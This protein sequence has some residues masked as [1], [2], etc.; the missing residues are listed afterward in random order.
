MREALARSDRDF[1]I[2]DDAE[3]MPSRLIGALQLILS[4]PLEIPGALTMA[5]FAV[6]IVFNALALQTG[7]HP[8]PFF[9]RPDQRQAQAATTRSLT[10]APVSGDVTASLSE[11]AALVRDL[12]LEL[13][14]VGLYDGTA[15]GLFGPRT[16]AAIR[17]YQEKVGL[18]QDGRASPDLLIRMR[19]TPLP[20]A[21]PAAP[22]TQPANGDAIA[23]LIESDMPSRAVQPDK[24]VLRV[25]RALS[26][27][28]YGPLKVDGI[29]DE[30]TRTAIGQFEMD[31]SM[32]VTG[33]ISAR[34]EKELTNMLGA[35]LE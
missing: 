5:G 26:K 19:S 14:E 28:A 16:A 20:P 31:R 23:A 25:E 3:E 22:V 10:P 8:Q 27:L 15:D 7:M 6:A 17:V 2:S 24:R 9:A 35:P 32:P 4:H 21:R 13:S 30:E 1:L 11:Q 12:Q 29:A 33:K 34:L 18:A